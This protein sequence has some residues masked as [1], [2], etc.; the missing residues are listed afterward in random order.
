MFPAS[1]MASEDP[2]YERDRAIRTTFLVLAAVG[3][4]VT[5]TG[6][7][8]RV[9]DREAPGGW[10]PAGVVMGIMDGIVGVVLLTDDDL[11]VQ[12]AGAGYAA[13]GLANLGLALMSV[14]VAEDSPL[15]APTVLSQG[16]GG[17]VPGLAMSVSF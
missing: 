7:A 9:R 11:G 12:M 16:S 8:L 3:G 5:L 10:L 1:A 2:D 13:L 6:L 4:G 15:L 14:I 17:L